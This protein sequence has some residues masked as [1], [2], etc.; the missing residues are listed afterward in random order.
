MTAALLAA[1]RFEPVSL[2]VSRVI[3]HRDWTSRK[4]DVKQDLTWWH[5]V[6]GIARR[7]KGNAVKT[8]AGITAFI[9]EHP[10]GK[11]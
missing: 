5:A 6:I 4:P 3:R 8:R 9:K 1:M 2:P 11:V 10:N 7:S